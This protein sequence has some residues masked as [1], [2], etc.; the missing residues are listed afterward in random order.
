MNPELAGLIRH[1]LTMAGSVL[2]TKGYTDSTALE[3]IIGGIMAVVALCWSYWA[4]QA[5]NSEAVKIADKVN[6]P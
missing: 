1:G 3:A 5:T 2:V 6:A 4:K